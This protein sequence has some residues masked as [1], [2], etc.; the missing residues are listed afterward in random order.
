MSKRS[1]TPEP[2]YGGHSLGLN[3]GPREVDRA[4]SRSN[5]SKHALKVHARNLPNRLPMRGGIRM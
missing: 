4:Q 1:R 3:H 2:R 5:F